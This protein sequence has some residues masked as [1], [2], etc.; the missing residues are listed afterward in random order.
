MDE[1]EEIWRPVIGAEGKYSVSSLGRVRTEARVA[2]RRNG[3]PFP[4]RERLLSQCEV[5]GGYRKVAIHYEPDV[6]TRR[7]VHQLVMEAFVGPRPSG[8]EICHGNGDPSDNRLDN[9]R[10]D[11]RSANQFDRI[12][13]G[14]HNNAGKTH[15]IRGHEFTEANT[16]TPPSRPHIRE[17][18]TCKRARRYSSI[19]TRAA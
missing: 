16:Y 15:C 19:G 5:Q 3:W 8:M 13:H 12:S 18:W 10:Y 7:L 4:V 1:N 2:M 9:L 6:P 17:C 14:R 11:T